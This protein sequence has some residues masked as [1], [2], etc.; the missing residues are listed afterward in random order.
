MRQ[1][2]TKNFRLS[3]FHSKDGIKV[4]EKYYHNVVALARQLQALRAHLGL[5]III[6]S[7]FRSA[8]HNKAV[9]GSSGSYHLFGMAGDFRVVGMTTARVYTEM[10]KLIRDGKML[11]GGMKCYSTFI[12]YDIRTNPTIF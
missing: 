12:H 1:Q 4:P 5:P 3:E 8:T 11:D 9:G 2:L 6:N 10:L 7:G